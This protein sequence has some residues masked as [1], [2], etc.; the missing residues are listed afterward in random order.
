MKHF[1]GHK[2]L[3]KYSLKLFSHE[4]YHTNAEASLN[5]STH[6]PLQSKGNRDSKRKG[7]S[8]CVA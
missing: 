8:K 7:I 2:T 3:Q 1:T 5:E 6:N 4:Q